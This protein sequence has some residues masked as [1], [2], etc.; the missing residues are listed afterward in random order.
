MLCK[1]CSL[2]RCKTDKEATALV[3]AVPV[4]ALHSL[5]AEVDT[6]LGRCQAALC[7]RV[8][9][10]VLCHRAAGCKEPVGTLPDDS[11]VCCQEDLLT[12]IGVQPSL[13]QPALA[14]HLHCSTPAPAE[15]RHVGCAAR[16]SA[17]EAFTCSPVA[18]QDM[19]HRPTDEELL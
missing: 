9:S 15:F 2:V 5:T 6:V 11:N 19:S 4:L 3:A 10:K 17:A 8:Q 12:Y 16:Q 13:F 7:K 14:S 1:S 18:I